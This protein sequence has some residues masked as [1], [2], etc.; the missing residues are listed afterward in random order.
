VLKTLGNNTSITAIIKDQ[1]HETFCIEYVNTYSLDDFKLLDS[2]KAALNACQEY[3]TD[4][5]EDG[6]FSSYVQRV[7]LYL[8]MCFAT[9]TLVKRSKR[10]DDVER[11][12]PNT[13]GAHLPA[14]SNDDIE[15]CKSNTLEIP[16]R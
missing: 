14:F 6:Q 16:L 12:K 10:I 4:D 8:R 7:L 9:T 1:E 11:C 15:Q 5:E 2:A 3:R 13:P